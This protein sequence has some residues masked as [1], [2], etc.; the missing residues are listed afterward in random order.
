MKK[1]SRFFLRLIIATSIILYNAIFVTTIYLCTAGPVFL[2]YENIETLGMTIIQTEPNNNEKLF[3]EIKAELKDS[4]LNDLKALNPHKNTFLQCKCG[5]LKYVT[6]F[7]NDG[8]H[9][10]I[11]NYHYLVF[12]SNGMLLNS[13]QIRNIRSKQNVDSLYSK[14]FV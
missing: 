7:Y 5:D 13:F 12:D 8:T 1:S 14:Y 4:Y 2:H 3:L 9:V 10:E 11:G 6:L